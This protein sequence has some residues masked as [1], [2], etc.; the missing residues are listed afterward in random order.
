MWW[1]SLLVAAPAAAQDEL[2]VAL[3]EKGKPSWE[4]KGKALESF[5]R[6]DT[7]RKTEAYGEAVTML[8]E[9]LTVQ[10]GCGK[11]LYALGQSFVG[12]KRWDD[13]VRVGDHLARLY[14][15]H[16]EG[17]YLSALAHTRARRPGDAV[18]AWDAFLK[19]DTGNLTG[20]SQ[21]N[22]A[23][24]RLERHDDADK[25]LG[26]A[27]SGVSE[28][29]LACLRTEIALGRGAVDDARLAFPKCD[30]SGTVDLQR[31]V[32][33]WLLLQEGKAG[34][35]QS[36]LA[37]GGAE[38]DTRL[39]LALVRLTEGK[40]DQ[41]V[42]LTSRLVG[43][44]PWALDARLAHARA[45]H[46]Q[47]KADEALKELDAALTGDGWQQ[48][49]AGYGRNDVILFLASPNRAK[50]V[51]MEALA[52]KIL[53]LGGKGDAAGAEALRQAAIE[54][55]GASALFPEPAP[56]PAATPATK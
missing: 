7:K 38:L 15:D 19:V 11:C 56:A 6:G 41:A 2:T 9:S 53:I 17:P 13:A 3:A 8:V 4:P 24:L 30:E 22:L 10:P 20:W 50:D 25:A 46:G 27:G 42:N 28:G 54:A 44:E 32:E 39:S 29:D 14:P 31:Q 5:G 37:Q 55:H 12:Q 47:G 52:L 40:Y 49:H 48:R 43:D 16:K 23:Y 35:A 18:A 21:R 45:L 26:A 34:E 1:L 51:C 33:G 36:K